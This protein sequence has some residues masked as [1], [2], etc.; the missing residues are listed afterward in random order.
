M[1]LSRSLLLV[2][3]ILNWDS[4]LGRIFG[5]TRKMAMTARATTKTILIFDFISLIRN[6]LEDCV[7]D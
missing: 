4:F 6:S 1:I 2:S 3:E 7:A 5:R